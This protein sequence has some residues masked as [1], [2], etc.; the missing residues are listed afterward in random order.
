M[1]QNVDKFWVVELFRKEFLQGISKGMLGDKSRVLKYQR[2]LHFKGKWVSFK[3][4]FRLLYG[5]EDVSFYYPSTDILRLSD[6]RWT[7]D[8]TLKIDYD[9]ANN[10]TV[11]EGRIVKGATSNVTAVVERTVTYQV[12]ATTISELYLSQIDANNATDG[13]STFSSGETITTTN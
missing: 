12:G 3:Y 2:L 4:I 13:Y 8:K 6:G 5:K 10:F 11:F 7:L 9:Q 1:L